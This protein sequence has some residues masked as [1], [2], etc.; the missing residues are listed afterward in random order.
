MLF[1]ALSFSARMK[2]VLAGRCA[3]CYLGFL[4]DD[5]QLHDRRKCR[6]KEHASCVRALHSCAITYLTRVCNRGPEA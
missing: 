4:H 6:E 3:S 2:C 1:V 5:R